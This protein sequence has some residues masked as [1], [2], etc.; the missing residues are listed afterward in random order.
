[1]GGSHGNM[2]VIINFFVVCQAVGGIAKVFCCRV[3]GSR[4]KRC[5][6]A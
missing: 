3:V 1:M 2:K 6:C 5:F 4:Y